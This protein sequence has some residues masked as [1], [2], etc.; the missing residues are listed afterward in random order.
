MSE[1][2]PFFIRV[3]CLE[4]SLVISC[5]VFVIYVFSIVYWYRSFWRIESEEL[6]EQ[7][8]L[9]NARDLMLYVIF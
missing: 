9:I 8:R 5:A 1:G 7:R 2:V 3:L 6:N 4:S